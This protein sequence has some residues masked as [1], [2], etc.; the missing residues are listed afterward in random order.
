MPV[1][2]TVLTF[3]GGALAT[4]IVGAL[5]RQ[6]FERGRVS[7][8]LSSVV[9]ARTRNRLHY[10]LKLRE[11]LRGLL[12][13]RPV[14]PLGWTTSY[15]SEFDLD[16]AALQ[17]LEGEQECAFASSTL[18]RFLAELQHRDVKDVVYDLACDEVSSLFVR[19][20]LIAHSDR[21]PILPDASKQPPIAFHVSTDTQV[22]DGKTRKY[23]QLELPGNPHP[24]IGDPDGSEKRTERVAVYIYAL[25]H[26]DLD[27]LRKLLQLGKEFADESRLQYKTICAELLSIKDEEAYLHTELV[28][29]N[30]G[31]A[32]LLLSELIEMRISSKLPWLTLQR[33]HFDPERKSQP[34]EVIIADW[35]E[36]LRREFPQLL[37]DVERYQS[38]VTYIALTPGS[39]QKMTFVSVAP[40][41]GDVKQMVGVIRNGLLDCEIRVAQHFPRLPGILGIFAPF[42]AKK[43]RT[44]RLQSTLT[45]G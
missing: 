10:T 3:M 34:P 27:I 25:S 38:T 26:C 35:A 39:A 4:A 6:Y 17:A 44:Q 45:P 18:T 30:T 29:T 12:R 1:M 19:N 28:V 13:D 32:P 8:A 14:S 24:I 36:R 40:I 42:V 5:T 31:R 7:F 20:A 41:S 33:Q 16:M 2:T 22:E 21:A 23:V 9:V 37:A 15:F 11:D 43:R